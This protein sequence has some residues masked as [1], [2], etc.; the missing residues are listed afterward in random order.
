MRF[1]AKLAAVILAIAFISEILE[2]V[3]LS[4]LLIVAIG[5]GLTQRLVSI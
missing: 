1:L 4:G 3:E 5:G 2:V